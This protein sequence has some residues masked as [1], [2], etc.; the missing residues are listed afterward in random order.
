MRVKEQKDRAIL[1]KERLIQMLETTNFIVNIKCGE[2]DKYGRVL[3]QIYSSQ[4]TKSLNQLLIDE[5]HAYAYFG[6]TK[7]N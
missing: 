2:F 3:V 7:I 5:N 4:F 6:K 1:A